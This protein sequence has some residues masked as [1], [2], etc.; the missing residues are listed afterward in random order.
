M[1]L[2]GSNVNEETLRDGDVSALLRNVAAALRAGSTK[3]L[4]FQIPCLEVVVR[5]QWNDADNWRELGHAYTELWDYT[6]STE[7]LQKAVTA[8]EYALRALE[9]NPGSRSD[10]ANFLFY[11]AKC[12][13]QRFNHLG[14]PTDIDQSILLY[15]DALALY[16]GGSVATMVNLALSLQSRFEF[17]GSSADLEEAITLSETALAVLPPN[18]P[19]KPVHLNALALGLR[20]RFR[21]QGTTVDLSRAISLQVEALALRVQAPDHPPQ[22]VSLSLG[23]SLFLRYERM[24]SPGDLDDAFAYY[25]E[26][27][28]MYPMGDQAHWLCLNGIANCLERRFANNQTRV[29]DLEE[30]ITLRRKV[31]TFFPHNH[32][33]N[34]MARNGLARSLS[35]RFKFT[36][37]IVDLEEAIHLLQTSLSSLT[38]GHRD[39]P[40]VLINLCNAI[41]ERFKHLGDMEDREQA[42]LLCREAVH[43][44]PRGHPDWCSTPILSLSFKASFEEAVSPT[45]SKEST[46]ARNNMA[47]CF[48]SWYHISMHNTPFGCPHPERESRG[49]LVTNDILVP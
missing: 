16:E 17:H 12:L 27:L 1:V 34:V 29:E 32:P 25:R 38:A 49:S 5:L 3:A 48:D 20:H 11:L 44:L 9:E 33:R 2:P 13:W 14:D 22:S 21:D 45:T 37:F 30:A 26:G 8:N 46:E 36:G 47:F 31:L 19:D 7:S 18:D 4:P 41:Q 35:I 42:D 28:N 24:G 40:G 10:R 23:N 43:L 39:R 6:S 15:R